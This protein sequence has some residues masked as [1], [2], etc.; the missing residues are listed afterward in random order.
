MRPGDLLQPGINRQEVGQHLQWLATYSIVFLGGLA[1]GAFAFTRAWQ[2]YFGLALAALILVICSWAYRPRQTLNVTVFLAL[3]GDIVTVSWFPFNKNLSSVESILF[4]SNSISLSPLELVLLSG[5]CVVGARGIAAGRQPLELGAI[6]RP[7]MLFTVCVFGGLALGLG[8][9]GDFRAAMYEMRP[10]LYFPMVYVL[11]TTLVKTTR[12]QRHLVAAAVAAVTLQALL[13][14]DYLF[15]LDPAQREALETLT[16]HGAAISANFVFIVLLASLMY[17]GVSPRQRIVLAVAAAPVMWVYIVSQR[18]AAIITIGVAVMLLCATLLWRQRRTFWKVTPMLTIVVVAYLGAFWNSEASIAFP[19][20]AVKT[21]VA[22]G[23]LSEKDAS[24]DLY[25]VVENF[26]VNTTIRSSPFVGLGFGQ[27]FLRPVQLPDIS[28]FE[29]NGY[30]PHNSFLWIWIKTGFAGFATLV[31]VFSRAISLGSIRVRSAPDGPDAVVA[32]AA[33]LF[34]VMY[35]VYAYVDV[36]WRSNN[37]V[38]L[39]VALSIA[40]SSVPFARR[41]SR[42]QPPVA[43]HQPA[44]TSSN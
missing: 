5:L 40:T 14:L 6:G 41:R 1:V 3:V 21:V 32:V 43:L 22:P 33:T 10:L 38:L 12:H 29:F 35:A 9:G 17:R 34:V 19:A 11:A 16:A 37:M 2:P 39:G 4:I 30:V 15:D 28:R 20:N 13:S 18:R 26:N 44:L 25:R 24:S 8:T 27:E 42:P 7:L 31:Y 23:E 36:A